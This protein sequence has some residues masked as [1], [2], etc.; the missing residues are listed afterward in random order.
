MLRQNISG[1]VLCINKTIL[2]GV[3]RIEQLFR[4]A[5]ERKRFQET[6][7]SRGEAPEGEV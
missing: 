5:Q 3:A 2:I 6:T 1:K 4:C 7:S